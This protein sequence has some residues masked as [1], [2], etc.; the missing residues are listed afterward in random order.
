MPTSY[1]NQEPK[2][3][4]EERYIKIVSYFKKY[5]FLGF[6]PIPLAYGT[7]TPIVKRWNKLKFFSPPPPW[8]LFNIGWRLDWITLE[9][10]KEGFLV[11]VDVD[12]REIAKEL[13]DILPQT[14][15]QKS[16]GKHQGFHFFYLVDKPLESFRVC[17]G[18]ELKGR[19]SQVVVEP[20]LVATPYYFIGITKLKEIIEKITF[21]EADNLLF[22]L[23][24]YQ[25]NKSQ[26]LIRENIDESRKKVDLY[27]PPK[28]EYALIK[29]QEEEKEI[30][31]NTL[32]SVNKK[33]KSFLIDFHKLNSIFSISDFSKLLQKKFEIRKP[34][35]CP[36][37]FEKHPSVA[38][39][40]SK[41]GGYHL[42]DFHE[43]G[44]RKVYSFLDILK[45]KKTKKDEP[46]RPE[47]AIKLSLE[48]FD[49]FKIVPQGKE[50]QRLYNR[51]RKAFC[52]LT[53]EERK[54]LLFIFDKARKIETLGLPYFTLSV[55][56]LSRTLGIARQTVR[57]AINLLVEI[58]LLK[59][60]GKG[61][62][63]NYQ[64][65]M[66]EF[67]E[68]MRLV[69][70][71]KAKEKEAKKFIA[72]TLAWLCEMAKVNIAYLYLESL[73]LELFSMAYRKTKKGDLIY[74]CY[75]EGKEKKRKVIAY[76]DWLNKI[77]FLPFNSS[78]IFRKYKAFCKD[79]KI[80]EEF[81]FEYVVL[82]LDKKY[83]IKL[84]KDEFFNLLEKTKEGKL[85]IIDHPKYGK[86]FLIK[87]E[88]LEKLL[89][90]QRQ[91][92]LFE[93]L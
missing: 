90:P 46:L 16:G 44:N 22:L 59:L 67:R 66:R 56:Y 83:R 71:K 25:T 21:I 36:I 4:Q 12:N 70:E 82:S 7:K 89:K 77:L 28:K 73:L 23:N 3:S 32:T 30:E 74:L 8:E 50:T 1:C 54:I 49:K 75:S 78:N 88:I 63:L 19:G 38:I 84:R 9:N 35:L 27:L 91:I 6:T 65:G 47:E 57:K 62:C 5:Q 37:H 64:M 72:F 41:Y 58:N 60:N 85:R 45:L 51:L 48:A 55:R 86:Q 68:S 10:G 24:S 29:E 52:L 18:I 80:L 20:S 69:R 87:Q 79:Y 2:K 76:F 40:E 81:D 31:E 92:T 26:I 34:F 17:E 93:V 42:V 11:C 14:L 33:A 39:Y 53:K 13:V 15:L 61:F 43:K